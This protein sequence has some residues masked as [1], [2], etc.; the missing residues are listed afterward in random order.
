[1]SYEAEMFKYDTSSNIQAE[2]NMVRMHGQSRGEERLW[3]T[4]SKL[5]R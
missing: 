1:M 3:V 4:L 5:R 2:G